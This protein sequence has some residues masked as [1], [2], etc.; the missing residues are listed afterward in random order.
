M[1]VKGDL[2]NLIESFLFERQQRFVLNGQKYE[3]LKVKAGVPQ[4]S[5]LGPFFF[6][7]IFINDLS[8]NRKSHVKLFADDTSIFSV[9]SDSINTSQ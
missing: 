9:V 4:D 7:L 5:F 8:G 3:G 1:C 6:F 2:L